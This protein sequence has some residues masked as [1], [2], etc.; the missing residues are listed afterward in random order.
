L[1]KYEEICETL[2]A[3]EENQAIRKY[4]KDWL[5]TKAL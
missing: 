3:A 5:T 1:L 4:S 2:P